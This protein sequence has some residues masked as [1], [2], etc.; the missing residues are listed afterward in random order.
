MIKVKAHI[1]GLGVREVEGKLTKL[2]GYSKQKFFIYK[3]DKYWSLREFYTG[4]EVGYGTTETGARQ[5]AHK[6]LAE[7]LHDQICNQI[8][9]LEYINED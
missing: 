8:E 1:K 7:Y 3:M 4:R 5:A 6:Y 9:S 2:K